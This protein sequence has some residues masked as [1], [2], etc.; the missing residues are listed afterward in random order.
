MG[1]RINCRY[2]GRIVT[3]RNIARHLRQSCKV[4]DPGGGGGRPR[5]AVSGQK[6][7]RRNARRKLRARRGRGVEQLEDEVARIRK[8]IK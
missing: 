2:C 7:K 3:P 5:S 6:R 4:W 8:E 1:R